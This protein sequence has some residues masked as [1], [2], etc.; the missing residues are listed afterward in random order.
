[1]EE[2]KDIIIQMIERRILSEKRKHETNLPDEWA[3]IAAY[4]I[5]LSILDIQKSNN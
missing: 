1:M 3:K 4:K 5:Y 2:N